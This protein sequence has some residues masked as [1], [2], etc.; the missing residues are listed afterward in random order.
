MSTPGTRYACPVHT[1]AGEFTFNYRV[2]NAALPPPAKLSTANT[3]DP[4]DKKVG[5]GGSARAHRA[6]ARA[7]LP[8]CL[9][10]S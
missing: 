3:A 1:R 5:G 7:A 8:A 9:S 6:A 10:A 2:F 4:K